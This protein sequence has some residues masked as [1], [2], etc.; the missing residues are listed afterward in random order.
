MLKKALRG[1][2][3]FFR[4][5][6]EYCHERHLTD[7]LDIYVIFPL[8]NSAEVA[9][10]LTQAVEEIKAE[11]RLI[12]KAM[13]RLSL[14]VKAY[15]RQ[16]KTGKVLSSEWENLLKA[17]IEKEKL[18]RQTQWTSEGLERLRTKVTAVL[19]KTEF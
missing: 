11:D 19:A 18:N 17:A 5:Y 7:N 12:A 14:V 2:A 9:V 6:R 15:G 13:A 1:T 10:K 4:E 16:K 3:I 8:L